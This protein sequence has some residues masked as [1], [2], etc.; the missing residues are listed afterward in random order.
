MIRAGFW[1]F[2]SHGGA[3]GRSYYQEEVDNWQS[4]DPLSQPID[5]EP[6][7]PIYQG[8]VPYFGCG[9]RF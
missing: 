2:T 7:H 5:E 9:I 6:D 4:G 1:L 8:F 3:S